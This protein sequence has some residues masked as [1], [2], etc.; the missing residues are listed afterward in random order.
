MLHEALSVMESGRI[1]HHPVFGKDSFF[2]QTSDGDEFV[3]RGNTA[4][5]EE[6]LTMVTTLK[7]NDDRWEFYKH[8]EELP[9]LRFDRSSGNIETADKGTPIATI[10]SELAATDRDSPEM[11]VLIHAMIDAYNS[12]E[13]KKLV[14]E[15]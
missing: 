9:F 1:V 8:G 14:G 13:I 2:Y 5:R 6:F 10:Y 3:G 12:S 11:L 4:S 7:A 15:N